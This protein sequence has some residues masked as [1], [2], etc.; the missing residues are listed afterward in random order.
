MKVFAQ[1]SDVGQLFITAPAIANTHTPLP[2]AFCFPA[3]E[4]EPRCPTATSHAAQNLPFCGSFLDMPCDILSEDVYRN[5]Y[6][7]RVM[8]GKTRQVWV[9]F[10]WGVGLG[11]NFFLS[12]KA[13]MYFL[14]TEDCKCSLIFSL[15]GHHYC[16]PPL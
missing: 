4:C 11:W 10:F 9:W 13:W 6:A 16:F 1:T 12:R 7:G 5:P 2:R 15:S 8:G 14:K 3:C